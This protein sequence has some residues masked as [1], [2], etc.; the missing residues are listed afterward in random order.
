MCELLVKAA[1]SPVSG[2]PWRAGMIV[3]IKPD[4]H[5]WGKKEAPPAFYLVKVPG[6]SVGSANQYLESW[7]H[8]PK[9][10]LLSGDVA[11]DTYSY[12][13]KVD[14]SSVK[15]GLT[16]SQVE[17]YFTNWGCVITGN[18]RNSVTFTANIESII[19]S[20]GFWGRDVSGLGF[21][22]VYDSESGAHII[23]VA[24]ATA[25]QVKKACLLNDVEYISPL[26]YRVTR[27]QARNRMA[28]DI[29]EQFQ[30]IMI[31][32]RRWYLSSA[33]MSALTNAGG[34]MTVTPGQLATH[35]RDGFS[36]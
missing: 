18:T 26:S 30:K 17:S 27:N 10:T 13:M 14:V 34:V 36:D 11:A 35:L 4:G 23:T 28:E 33:A 9:F 8:K 20:N 12:E 15:G 29:Y 16:L 31:E 21:S 7:H 1:D 6:V 25:K 3:T 24:G 19:T 2:T 5:E 32:K 22:D